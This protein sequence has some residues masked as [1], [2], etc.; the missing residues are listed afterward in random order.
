[1]PALAVMP[2]PP[3]KILKRRIDAGTVV[4]AQLKLEGYERQ[5][6]NRIIALD[7]YR[8]LVTTTTSSQ[9]ANAGAGSSAQ[10]A[11]DTRDLAKFQNVLTASPPFRS[12]ADWSWASAD[13]QGKLHFAV[14]LTRCFLAVT[15]MLFPDFKPNIIKTEDELNFIHEARDKWRD[16]LQPKRGQC[17][18]AREP[19]L[20]LW[21]GVECDVRMISQRKNAHGQVTYT[22]LLLGSGQGGKAMRIDVHRF[23][24][25]LENASPPINDESG[26][27]YVAAHICLNAACINPFH[28]HWQRE[29]DNKSSQ[30]RKRSRLFHTDDPDNG[31]GMGQAPQAATS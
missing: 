12:P 28:L 22:A 19:H 21:N 23:V 2:S 15:C 1:M 8:N 26:Q 5:V 6:H 31:Q 27:P 10:G 4:K 30:Q 24:C 16:E 3:Q 9:D 29:R 13:N 11:H 7:G 25:W 18:P 14:L 17:M 20:R